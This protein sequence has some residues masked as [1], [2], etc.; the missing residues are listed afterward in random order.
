M[1]LQAPKSEEVIL[2]KP[3]NRCN[4][5][6]YFNNILKRTRKNIETQKTYTAQEILSRKQTVGR[7][8]IPYLK[9]ISA[10]AVTK[11]AFYCH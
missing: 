9:L 3:T 8:T 11:T 2:S 5:H 10:M 7:G 1:T 4:S 6:Q